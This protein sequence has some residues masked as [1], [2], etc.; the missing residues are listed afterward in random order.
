MEQT[1]FILIHLV[2]P[3][4]GVGLFLQLRRKMLVTEVEEP[5]ILPLLILFATYGGLIVAIL[6]ALFWYW[7]G[8]ATLGL[9]YLLLVAPVVTLA[10]AIMFY[11]RRRL[12]SFH[13]ATFWLGLA[14]VPCL[15]LLAAA[16]VVYY[17][18][19]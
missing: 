9:A 12:S 17:G 10:L 6:T 4:A 2:L 5:P 14:Y 18:L 16:R 13:A 19:S 8:M 11:R 3:L 1:R 7:S 15:I